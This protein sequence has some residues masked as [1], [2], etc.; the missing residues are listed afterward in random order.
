[1]SEYVGTIATDP[2]AGGPNVAA[3]R[4]GEQGDTRYQVVSSVALGTARL[5]SQLLSADGVAGDVVNLDGDYSAT[6][7]TVRIAPPANTVMVINTLT[8]FVWDSD[9][10]KDL[11]E[12]T[13]GSRVTLSRSGNTITDFTEGFTIRSARHMALYTPAIAFTS[14]KDT[15][16][17]AG[18]FAFARVWGAALRLDGNASEELHVILNDD[19]T[20]LATGGGGEHYWRAYGWYE[21]EPT[22]P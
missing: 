7:L 20:E 1:M 9:P 15:F 2:G 12:L 14:D 16:G 22:I 3:E 11:P 19:F 18:E 21:S 4:R 5:V 10:A 6:P 13:V 8:M 17:V